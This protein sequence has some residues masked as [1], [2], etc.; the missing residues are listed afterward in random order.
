MTDRLIA[1]LNKVDPLD[2]NI[3]LS[4][5]KKIKNGGL[6]VGCSNREENEK[7]RQL[8]AE[9]LAADYDIKEVKG[10]HPRIRVVGFTEKFTAEELV[11]YAAKM[12]THL[13]ADGW[14]CSVLSITP[15][16][17]NKD[18]HQAVL[19]LDRTTYYNVMKAGYMFVGYD[20]CQIYDA[21]SVV[22]CFNCNGYNHSARACSKPVS[23]PRCRLDHAV[24]DC[25][26][27]KLCCVNCGADHA[28]WDSKCP[29]Y[30]KAV[31]KLR[32]DLLATR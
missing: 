7:L 6:L 13:F 12:N 15:T 20:C 26:S 17:R 9:K 28:A 27:D 30:I 23:C 16:K 18:I 2:T 22:R 29:V 25:S 21:I 31:D 19:Q 10:I 8:A 3:H 11:Q 24:T 1:L 14:E 32:A 4:K 5:V